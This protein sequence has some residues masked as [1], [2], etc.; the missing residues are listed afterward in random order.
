[1]AISRGSVNEYYVLTGHDN[2]ADM[3]ISLLVAKQYTVQLLPTDVYC[4][5]PI[6]V[7]VGLI[8]EH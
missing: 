5:G 7:P 3:Q 4:E 8:F 2:P 1:M 6:K